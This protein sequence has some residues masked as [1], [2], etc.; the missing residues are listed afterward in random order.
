MN[1]TTNTATTLAITLTRTKTTDVPAPIAGHIRLE[2]RTRKP[3]SRAYTVDVPLSMWPTADDVPTV[4][5]ALVESALIDAGESA[6]AT[7]VTSRA[8]AGNLNIPTTLLSLD[9][10]LTNTAAKRMT[11]ALL[12]GM[13]RNSTKYVMDVAPKLASY[14][15]SAQLR[16]AANIERH[17]K[18]LAALVGRSPELSLSAAD[19][20]K[21]LVNLHEDDEST[22]FGE[23]LATRTEEVRSKLAEDSEA[24]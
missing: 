18:R 19:L 15:G 20:D 13:W 10:L 1:A 11:V 14:T 8:T 5:R 3:E 4:F 9:A 16:Y 23:F 22:P 21:L 17:E 7:F 12:L 6:L 2:T 24:L